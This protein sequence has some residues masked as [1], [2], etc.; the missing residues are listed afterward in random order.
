MTNY[1]GVPQGTVH[2][3]LIFILSINK[4]SDKIKSEEVLRFVDNTCITLPLCFLNCFQPNEEVEIYSRGQ[5]RMITFA[6]PTVNE[7]L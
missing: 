6:T 7:L 5:L 4:F 3:T 1:R 2:G